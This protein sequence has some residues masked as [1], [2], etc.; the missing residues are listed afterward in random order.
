MFSLREGQCYGLYS[1][2]LNHGGNISV[3]HVKLT[4]SAATALGSFQDSKGLSSHP[5]IRF[6]GNQGRITI[7]C[8]ERDGEM[9]T[10][11]FYKTTV[12]GDNP[13]GSLDLVQQL[14]TGDREEE[15]LCSV[16]VIQDKLTVNA[17]DDSYN[18]ARQ[19]LAQAEEETRSRGAIVIKPGGRYQGKKVTVRKPAPAL[20][21]PISTR[22]A[23][24]AHTLKQG[25]S[26]SNVKTAAC[27]SNLKKGQAIS[28]LKQRLSAFK[29]GRTAPK[30]KSACE[31]GVSGCPA[32][33]RP[34]RERLTH[35]LA[36]RP[37]RRAELVLRLQRDGLT[38]AER[39]TLDTLLLE[40]GQLNAKDNTYLLKDFLYKELQKD[41]A[42]YNVGDQQLL[43]RILVRRLFQ[44]H[45]NLLTVPET[46]VSPLRD[47]PNSSP[48]HPQKHSHPEEYTDPLANKKPR[49]SLLCSKAANVN[50]SL[51]SSGRREASKRA[52]VAAAT[53]GNRKASSL[54]PRKL[55]DCLSEVSQ[56]EGGSVAKS[57]ELTTPS[58]LEGSRD[59]MQ[60]HQPNAVR[61]PS[62]RLEPPDHERHSRARRKRKRSHKEQDRVIEG[63][64]ISSSDCLKG[65]GSPDC[66]EPNGMFYNPSVLQANNDTTDY[67]LKYTVICNREQRLSYKQD[68]N[69]EYQEYRELHAS[70]DGVTQQFMGLDKQLKQ[71]RYGSNKYKTLHNKILQDYRA[72]KKSNPNY[73]KDKLRCEYLHNKLAHIKKLISEYDQQQLKK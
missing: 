69:V 8:A 63:T 41:W 15:Q 66:L 57:L 28:A 55:F 38:T 62:P 23:I 22:T 73:G 58:A 71:L 54:D 36:L 64:G 44:P 61:P 67:L 5:S 1:R 52:P 53:E 20:A 56:Q 26:E 59:S 43:K 13:H 42:G 4:D 16:G 47:T 48:A 72:I 17:T 65:E 40:V 25:E 6:T 19:S 24:P 35:L 21:N 31:G 39:D 46:Q 10:F 70:I 51:R 68:F 45:H 11:T 37:Y 14:S 2:K 29:K 33:Q 32:E 7:P 12:V 49:I 18:K 50:P 30:L 3:F 27:I 60:L 34:L 9:R